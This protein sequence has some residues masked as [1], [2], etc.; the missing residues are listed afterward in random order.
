MVRKLVTTKMSE[1][2]LRLLRIAAALS[3]EDHSGVL[4]RLLEQEVA[5]LQ[6]EERRKK[7][8]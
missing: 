2:A 8:L 4:E 6:E 5:R 7:T 3:G 1:K